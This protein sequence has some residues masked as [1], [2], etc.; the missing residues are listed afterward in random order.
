MLLVSIRNQQLLR[1]RSKKTLGS[2]AGGRRGS[3]E[4]RWPSKSTCLQLQ[5]SEVNVECVDGNL[6]GETNSERA[7]SSM[8]FT[9]HGS[10]IH[11]VATCHNKPLFTPV[12]YTKSLTSERTLKFSLWMRLSHKY[13]H[14]PIPSWARSL[15][16]SLE[17]HLV[18]QLGVFSLFRQ[19]CR[20]VSVWPET[21]LALQAAWPT[22]F[23]Y[24]LPPQ[25]LNPFKSIQILPF[26]R[27]NR[28]T[29]Q[30]YVVAGGGE[31]LST[32][33]IR[34]Q[35]NWVHFLMATWIENGCSTYIGPI[36]VVIQ[37]GFS[38]GQLFVN[39]T[40]TKSL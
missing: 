28:S 9:D 26:F 39:L 40:M 36:H 34:I 22:C 38:C 23:F 10:K 17:H 30:L 1:K 16:A 25:G 12:S 13:L 24:M 19:I 32:E 35:W 33:Y 29:Q 15:L 21:S 27:T 5:G 14:F 7:K 8:S 20:G 11:E 18:D 4:K 6:Y 3:A 31:T 37:V 2:N